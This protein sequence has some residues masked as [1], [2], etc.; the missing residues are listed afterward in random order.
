MAKKKMTPAQLKLAEEFA[1]EPEW[2]W[3]P[4]QAYRLP[5]TAPSF[6]FRIVNTAPRGKFV[7]YETV[8]SFWGNIYTAA[9]HKGAVPDLADP[10]THDSLLTVARLACGSDVDITLVD[11]LA[12][13]PND[14]DL[15]PGEPFWAPSYVKDGVRIYPPEGPT[16]AEA[17]LQVLREVTRRAFDAVSAVGAADRELVAALDAKPS[18]TLEKLLSRAIPDDDHPTIL[19]GDEPL[20]GTESALYFDSLVHGPEQAAL[21]QSMINAHSL[22]VT[23]WYHKPIHDGAS[24][25]RYRFCVFKDDVEY[26]F[27]YARDIKRDGDGKAK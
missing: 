24:G 17:I 19:F 7:I 8:R 1:Q 4:G 15:R 13:D 10:I 2:R 14:P 12:I 25:Y 23:D 22:R 6:A 21:L 27:G 9:V 3:L 16:F 20:P 26:A 5:K 18:P 11:D